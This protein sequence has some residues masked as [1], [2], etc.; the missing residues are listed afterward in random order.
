MMKYNRILIVAAHPDDEVL[1]CGGTVR[2]L[3][4]QG[5]EVNLIIATNG[6]ESRKNI[7][8]NDEIIKGQSILKK[9][10]KLSAKILGIKN[11]E[12]CN[13]PDQ[14]LDTIPIIEI[15]QKIEQL[16]FKFKPNIIFTHHGGDLNLD[17]RLLHQAVLTA[18]RPLPHSIVN[19]IYVGETL[20]STEFTS[21]HTTKPF[22]PDTFFDIEETLSSKIKALKAYKIEMRNFPHSRSYKAVEHL[23]KLR[24]SMVGLRAAEAFITLRNIKR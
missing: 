22:L 9:S 10:T 11:I 7:L 23:A 12:Y 14:Y 16:I 20:S 2:K 6:M 24:G 1:F 5:H 18:T 8:K 13:F 4:K 17:H 3:T 19:K 15:T 21:Q